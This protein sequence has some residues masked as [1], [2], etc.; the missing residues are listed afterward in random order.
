MSDNEP[1]DVD[2]S[3]GG[4]RVPIL[5]NMPQDSFVTDGKSKTKWTEHTENMDR[6]ETI[7]VP[8][9]VSAQVGQSLSSFCN[10]P[11]F[12]LVFK[13][14]MIISSYDWLTLSVHFISSFKKPL[15]RCPY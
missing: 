2:I 10:S 11:M 7:D 5:R 13:L 15:K 3:G 8:S 6:L 9:S 1:A 12:R 14:M 4:N